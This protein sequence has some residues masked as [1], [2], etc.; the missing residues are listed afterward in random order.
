MREIHCTD[1]GKKTPHIQKMSA[2]L[3]GYMVCDACGRMNG[4][5]TLTKPDVET[6]EKVSAEIKWVEWME[7]GVGQPAKQLHEEPQVGYSLL[8][9]PFNHGFTWM[10]TVITEIIEQEEGYI[11][12]K[13]RNSV[14][15][16]RYHR[17]ED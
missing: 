13:T 4:I 6:F 16:L 2:S 12:F 14:Y 1:C 10:T 17:F 9:S 15:E 5:C 11:K 3:G 8:M 7:G